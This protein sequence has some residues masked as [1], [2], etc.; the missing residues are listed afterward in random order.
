MHA[1]RPFGIA[2]I[3]LV[4]CLAVLAILALIGARALRHGLEAARASNAR[5]HLLSSLQLAATRAGVT[6]RHAVLCPSANGTTCLASVEWSGGWIVFS[7][8]DEDGHADAGER[9]LDRV[10][11]LGGQ[12]RLRSTAGR[13]RVTFQGN[14]GN[15]GSNL[16]FTLCDGRGPAKARSLV[17]SNRGRLREAPA[18]AAAAAVTCPP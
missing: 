12:V 6:G 11:P 2:L 8:V 9:Q 3:E 13:T 17:L 1:R 10:A 14:S 7:D 4:A 16:T 18:S 5:A 15:A